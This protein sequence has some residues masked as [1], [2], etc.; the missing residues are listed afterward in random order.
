[1][2]KNSSAHILRAR[3][4][5]SLTKIAA[6]ILKESRAAL[7]DRRKLKQRIYDLFSSFHF[8]MD[9]RRVNAQFIWC[10]TAPMLKK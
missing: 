1:M 8:Y 9:D 2:I 3:P 7:H 6:D 10:R 5:L 4:G